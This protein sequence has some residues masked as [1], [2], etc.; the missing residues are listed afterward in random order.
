MRQVVYEE[1]EGLIVDAQQ[2]EANMVGHFRCTI[3]GQSA[4]SSAVIGETGMMAR[5]QDVAKRSMWYSVQ[6]MIQN[7][8]RRFVGGAAGSRMAR[9]LS[10]ELV[11]EA[12]QRTRHLYSEEQKR[13]AV[14]RAF[15]QVRASWRWDERMGQWV[16]ATG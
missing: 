7:F 11:G 3:S 15:E 2:K 1:I 16:W 13:A 4:Q 8:I 6:R 12:Q 5:V 10:R 9:E 14:V